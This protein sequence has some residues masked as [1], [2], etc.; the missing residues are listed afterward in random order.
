MVRI[1]RVHFQWKPSVPLSNLQPEIPT[2]CGP[3]PSAEEG[4]WPANIKAS[5]VFLSGMVRERTVSG[6]ESSIFTAKEIFPNCART[7]KPSWP[8][9]SSRIR[10]GCRPA[11]RFQGSFLTFIDAEI[12]CQRFRQ[13]S[14]FKRDAQTAWVS[15]ITQG[16]GVQSPLPQPKSI[17]GP[18]AGGSLFCRSSPSSP[19]PSRHPGLIGLHR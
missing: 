17:K 11:F 15:L 8:M 14:N 1:W 13:A 16:S 9:D 6:R 5:A 18:A 2:Q 3:E 12:Y 4:K 19:L 10:P 7:N